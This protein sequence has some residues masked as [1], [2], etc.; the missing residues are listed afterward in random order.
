MPLFGPMC[1]RERRNLVRPN[2]SSQLSFYSSLQGY[3]YCSSE[4]VK[5]FTKNEE[6]E[7]FKFLMFASM[8][9]RDW[10]SATISGAPTRV[11]IKDKFKSRI[12]SHLNTSYSYLG[13]VFTIVIIFKRV[14]HSVV[15]SLPRIASNWSKCKI[16]KDYWISLTKWKVKL[17]Y[18]F[19]MAFV[20]IAKQ[21]N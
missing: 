6:I 19:W 10:G 14:F 7:Q 9:I 13:L 4:T 1:I 16:L 5:K 8:C 18:S 20:L 17:Q 2:K 21:Y 15:I 12:T 11:I 3:H